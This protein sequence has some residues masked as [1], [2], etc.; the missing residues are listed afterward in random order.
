[1]GTTTCGTNCPNGQFFNSA[2]TPFVC[3]LCDINC[4][5]CSGISTN[6][7]FCWYINSIT[8]VFLT[9]TTS[10]LAKCA[11]SCPDGYWASLSAVSSI[12]NECTKCF[13]GCLT[14]TAGTNNTCTACTTNSIS[15]VYYKWSGQNVCDTTCP[16][17]QYINPTIDFVC[18][19][20]NPACVTCN[21]LVFCNSCVKPFF[22]DVQL[23]TCVSVCKVNY[24]GNT[25][26]ASQYICSQCTAGCY[27]CT[28]TGLLSCQSCQND[29]GTVYYKRYNGT[30]CTTICPIGS[31]A[32]DADNACYLCDTGCINC[33]INSTNCYACKTIG[34]VPYYKH[35]TL[36]KCVTECPDGTYNNQSIN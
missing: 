15:T 23:S 30:E 12:S 3:M 2:I 5:R 9:N 26:G 29:S 20:C 16:P 22:F 35:L 8:P 31:Y 13:D 25:T 24:Y 11:T 34:G 7:T 27:E 28:N 1:M 32:V 10:T 21:S 17:G 36:N 33:S 4:A 6:C 14:C 18:Q 19:I